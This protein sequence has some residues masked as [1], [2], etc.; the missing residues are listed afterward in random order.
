[1]TPDEGTAHFS[2]LKKIKDAP[3]LFAS[4][5]YDWV[6]SP[7]YVGHLADSWHTAALTLAS[8][9]YLLSD[10][11]LFTDHRSETANVVA[12]GKALHASLGQKHAL[13]L[14]DT[15]W[16]SNLLAENWGNIPNVSACAWNVDGFL[17]STPADH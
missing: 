11:W 9:V 2:D 4:H 1:M 16:G 6:G 15:E 7:W 13:G 8:S 12:W 10:S 3:Q 17:Q 5:G 14:V